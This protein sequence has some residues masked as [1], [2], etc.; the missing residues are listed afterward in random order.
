MSA[1]NWREDAIGSYELAI[2]EMRRRLVTARA[3][4]VW[5]IRTRAGNDALAEIGNRHG[6]GG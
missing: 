2:A 1:Y 6:E 5:L 4:L 3:R